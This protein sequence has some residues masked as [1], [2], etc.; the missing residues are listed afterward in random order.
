VVEP[1]RLA[2]TGPWHVHRGA[3]G[4]LPRHG[5]AGPRGL[6]GARCRLVAPGVARPGDV[7]TRPLAA[8]C[9]ARQPPAAR[10]AL[11]APVRQGA[12][13]LRHRDPGRSAHRPAGV[14]RPPAR[15]QRA[16]PVGDRRRLP[17]PPERDARRGEQQPHRRRRRPRRPRGAEP[18][19]GARRAGDHRVR[20]AHRTQLRGDDQHPRGL[21]CGDHA[22][23]G[24]AGGAA[25]AA[26]QRP[27]RRGG[28][29][30]VAA[31]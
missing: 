20:R 19:R 22:A 2:R 17:D 14:L 10:P 18:G 15:H 4:Q 31:G 11:P 25:A 6:L 3:A 7:P 29:P 5:P 12:Q 30:G 24:A 9:A 13:R 26:G 23:A 27:G 1:N 21:H 8:R 28:A 16:L